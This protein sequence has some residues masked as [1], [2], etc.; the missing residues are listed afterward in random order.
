MGTRSITIVRKRRPKETPSVATSVLGGPTESQYIYEYYVCIY[1][2]WDGYVEGGVGERLAEFLCKYIHDSSSKPIDTG[3]L[4]AKLV[5]EIVGK[6]THIFNFKL[7]PLA[8]LED[9]FRCYD[10]AFA[11]IITVDLNYHNSIMLSVI[12]NDILTARPNK[13]MRK[14]QHYSEQME[15]L[16]KSFEKVDYGDDE[17]EEEGY[18]SE[19]KLLFKFWRNL[20]FH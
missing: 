10:Y 8:P 16:G 11:Y 20:F 12:D 3:L 14:F 9:M 19:D 18:L 15:V 2:H 4:A 7:M 6:N 13:F 17:V 5:E 1:Q